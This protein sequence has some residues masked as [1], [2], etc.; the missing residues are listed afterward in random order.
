MV[1]LHTLYCCLHLFSL[2]VVWCFKHLRNC[3]LWI[4]KTEEAITSHISQPVKP[5]CSPNLC[6]WNLV[7]AFKWWWICWVSE[8][9]K[10]YIIGVPSKQPPVEMMESPMLYYNPVRHNTETASCYLWG[11]ITRFTVCFDQG[12]LLVGDTSCCLSVCLCWPHFG[13]CLIIL[14]L[15]HS[16]WSLFG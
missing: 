4:H 6:Q 13:S 15:L 1:K 5:F 3:T 2:S 7:T 14:G 10:P 16:W 8:H 9:L 12:R 11:Q